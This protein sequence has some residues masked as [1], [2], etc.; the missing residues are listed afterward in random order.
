V[1]LIFEKNI[2]VGGYDMKAQEKQLVKPNDSYREVKR[3][4]D[5]MVAT[6][7]LVIFFPIMLVVG[8][9]IFIFEREPVLFLQRRTG[10][11]KQEF[12]IIK[13]RTMKCYDDGNVHNYEW[14][15]Q[16]PQNFVFKTPDSLKVTRLGAILRKY[17]LDELPQL[18][19]VIKGDM[20][21]VGPRP[22]I[23][24]IT[25]YYCE[26]QQRRLLVK[27]GITGFAQVHGRSD[28]NHG[29]K[30]NYDLYYVNHISM[31]LDFKILINTIVLV[32]TGKGAY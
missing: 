11:F 29:M 13:F 1:K 15:G 21:L 4:L 24:N 25:K 9:L 20:S 17:S 19:N 28:I 27:P 30:I 12:T 32:F 6:I 22:E 3:L 10:Q 5:I 23:P 31:L 18:I 16:V 14:N 2:L 26:V 7:L 8:I